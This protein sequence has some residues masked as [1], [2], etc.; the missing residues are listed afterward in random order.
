ML[1]AAL[2][3]FRDYVGQKRDWITIVTDNKHGP[4]FALDFRR[5]RNPV[6]DAVE[7]IPEHMLGGE[8]LIV[9]VR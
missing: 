8:Q 9:A 1:P 6:I 5:Q 2:I 7:I 3:S 4:W